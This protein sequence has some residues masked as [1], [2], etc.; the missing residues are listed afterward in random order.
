MTH[1]MH[2][3]AMKS[4]PQTW[5]NPIIRA[6]VFSQYGASPKDAWRDFPLVHRARNGYIDQ[7][8]ATLKAFW[9]NLNLNTFLQYHRTET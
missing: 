9:T 1:F 3:K 6:I 5:N 4:T 7:L 2:W 8:G